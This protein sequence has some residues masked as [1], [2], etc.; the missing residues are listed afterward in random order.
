M[1]DRAVAFDDID[2]L[3]AQTQTQAAANRHFTA[4]RIDFDSAAH[5]ATTLGA[6][7]GDAAT[8]TDGG[9]TTAMTTLGLRLTG[10]VH[11]SAG[12]HLVTVRSDDGFL[13]KIGGQVVSSYDWDRGFSGTTQ[14]VVSTGGLYAVELYYFDNQGD[15]GL[16]LEIDGELA[17][18][19]LFYRS[20][21][22]YE[23][24]LAANGAAPAGGLPPVYD[25]PLG[26][27]GTG[28]DATIRVIGEDQGLAHRVSRADI[29]AGAAAADAINGMIVEAIRA[30]GA[31][32]DG[33]LTTAEVYDLSTYIRAHHYAAFLAAH[34][35]DDG[36]GDRLPPV[37]NDGATTRL[38]GENAINTVFDGIYHIGFETEWDRFLNEDGN[39]NARVETVAYWLND[40][41]KTDLAN[42][43]LKN[44]SVTPVVPTGPAGSASDPDVVASGAGVTTLATGARTLTLTG[45]A[46]HG[47]GNT[48]ANTL[49]GNALDNVL[50]GGAGDD[51]LD[52]GDGADTLIGGR[53]ADTMTGGRGDDAYFIDDAG[54]R[55]IE[56]AAVA[57]GVDTINIMR[58][59]TRYTLGGGVENLVSSVGENFVAFGNTLSNE[60]ATGRG[61]DQIDG[62]AGNDVLHAG[63]GDDFLIGGLGRDRL[64]GGY[65]ADRLSGGVDNDT[66]VVDNIGDVVIEAADGG[67]DTV[68]ASITWRLGATLENLVLTGTADINGSGNALANRITGNDGDNTLDGKGGADR[69][70]GGKGDD[71][72]VVDNTGVVVIE[73]AMGGVDL[74]R[75]SISVTLDTYVE[76]VALS[77]AA[78]LSATG[79]SSANLMRG[80][81]GSN[82]LNG[83]AG[84]D[85]LYGFDGNDLLDGGAG[86]DILLGGLGNDRLTGGAGADRFSGEAGADRFMFLDVGD[87]GV[88]T[89]QRDVILD[90]DRAQGDRIDLSAIDAV[91]G[92]ADNAFAVV[93]GFT[94]KAGQLMISY[95]GDAWLAQGDVNGDGL[96]D[97]AIEVRTTRALGATDF[98]L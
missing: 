71:T 37:Q 65:G 89:G 97:F 64:D 12:E 3:I 18:P 98:V 60:I 55:V 62:G 38:Y 78:N 95:M 27:T 72:Y 20:L 94:Q 84:E 80:N 33:V 83:M 92:G 35:D 47:I 28:L 50:D 58:G 7:L 73:T 63:A 44:A 67:I 88:A 74:V 93:G 90:Y 57:Y 81:A 91:L 61:N 11:L 32:N 86:A 31:A 5:D 77:G 48:L 70:M 29:A 30:T 59:F 56:N 1:F 66:Y 87:S 14:S 43:T 23:A 10:F 34:G 2:A 96:A 45:D 4:S 79:N 85:R 46:R 39:A 82:A 19:E 24:A 16:R 54:D 21:A 76:N 40:L 41:L 13:L 53:G 36:R 26:T 68:E 15:Q 69:L 22:D 42:G 49:R 6:F 25:G 17:G 75:A 52:G 9:A 8:L 51:A